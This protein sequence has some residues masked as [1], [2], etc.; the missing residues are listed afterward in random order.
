[1]FLLKEYK[2]YIADVHINEKTYLFNVCNKIL[3]QD[4]KHI[5]L[6]FKILQD[7]NNDRTNIGLFL[8]FKILLGKKIKYDYYNKNGWTCYSVVFYHWS[9]IFDSL[10]HQLI[11]SWCHYH[12]S[13]HFYVQDNIKSQWVICLNSINNNFI[14]SFFSDIINT[15]ISCCI[16]I[17]LNNSYNYFYDKVILSHTYFNV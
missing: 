12:R 10:F 9:D 3:F 16:N 7:I 11:N 8:L 4:I 1:M 13:N 17:V 15:N 6:K 2:R 14:N 5:K